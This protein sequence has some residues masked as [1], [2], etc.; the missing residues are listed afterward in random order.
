MGAGEPSGHRCRLLLG[1]RGLEA[2]ALL[3]AIMVAGLMA[4]PGQ[5]QTPRPAVS[6]TGTISAEPA[7]QVALTIRITPSEAVPKGSF[8]R[9]RGLPPTV[10]LSE[11][12]S[13]APG[14]WAVPL[15]AL[16][17]LKMTL[18]AAASGQSEVS[19]M[20]V[21]LDGSLLAEART[22]LVVASPAAPP[23][24]RETQGNRTPATILRAGTPLQAP[25]TGQSE[26]PPPAALPEDRSIMSAEQRER[27]MRFLKRGDEHLAEGG[28]AQA[29]LLYERAAEAGLAQGA[30]ALA[31]TYDPAELER[32][33]VRGLRPDRAAALRWYEKARQLGAREAE[34][35][36]RR[37]GPN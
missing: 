23:P 27:A 31:A 12:H 13:I 35:R 33:G 20:L 26:L 29:R 3:A 37:L 5:T 8:V 17:A 18:P 4:G 30:M 2:F 19:I 32:L 10:A 36:L 21:G 11:G 28:I 7:S 24:E 14:S 9:I 25:S 34:Q 16:P 6:V 22:L 15:T 1:A